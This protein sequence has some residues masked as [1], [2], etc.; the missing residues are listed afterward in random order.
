MKLVLFHLLFLIYNKTIGIFILF[1]KLQFS[2]K[3]S[4]KKLYLL[5]KDATVNLGINYFSSVEQCKKSLLPSMVQ[6]KVRGG[7][8][9][10]WS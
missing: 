2:G 9:K 5:K 10:P 4:C 7:Q 3:S 8:Y 6:G 1:S